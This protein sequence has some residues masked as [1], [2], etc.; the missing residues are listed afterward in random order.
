MQNI[1]AEQ[2]KRQYDQRNAQSP[3]GSQNAKARHDYRG[4]EYGG[5]SQ[6]SGTD[7]DDTFCFFQSLLLAFSMGKCVFVHTV[8]T[9]QLY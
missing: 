4:Q 6:P 8:T 3:K 1:K 5:Y 7:E 2:N 9:F